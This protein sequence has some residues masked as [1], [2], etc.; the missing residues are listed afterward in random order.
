MSA[1]A[2]AE[3][4]YGLGHHTWEQSKE[5][6]VAYMKVGFFLFHGIELC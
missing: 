4:N 1:D 5:N 2:D 3:N 6:Y